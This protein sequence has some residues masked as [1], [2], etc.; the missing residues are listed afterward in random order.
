MSFYR[1][2]E[3]IERKELNIVFLGAFNPVII[4]PIWLASKSLIRESEANKANIKIIHNEVVEFELD[5]VAFNVT[6]RRFQITTSQEPYFEVVRDLVIGIF[7]ILKETPISAFGINH[8]HVI[9]LKTQERYYEFG[10]KICPLS[11]WSDTLNDARLQKVEIVDKSSKLK[12]EG[13]IT[14]TIYSISEKGLSF[15]V[16]FNIN[17]H[18]NF[19]EQSNLKF[20]TSY[21]SKYWDRSIDIANKLLINTSEALK[22]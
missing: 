19:D 10:N 6:Q 16:G 9:T 7:S 1:L 4:T 21:I 11:N 20:N 17:D 14:I 18:Y 8:N 22:L 13:S 5:W 15:V 2:D 3:N 12:D